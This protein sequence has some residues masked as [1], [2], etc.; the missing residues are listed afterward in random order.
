MKILRKS[1]PADRI[2]RILAKTILIPYLYT[3]RKMNE[4]NNKKEKTK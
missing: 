4:L 1:S 2:T 3:E